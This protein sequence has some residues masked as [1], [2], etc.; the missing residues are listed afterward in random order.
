MWRPIETAPKNAEEILLCCGP[1]GV[2][3][4]GYYTSDARTGQPGWVASTFWWPAKFVP[5]RQEPTHWQ[6]LL[7]LPTESHN[8]T[9]TQHETATDAEKHNETDS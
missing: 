2:M 6:P 1:T 8:A 3:Y 5:K 7:S 9:P 4:V